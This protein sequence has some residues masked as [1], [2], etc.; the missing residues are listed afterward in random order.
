MKKR[1]IPIIVIVIILALSLAGCGELIAQ[2][3]KAGAEIGE[4]IHDA[5][6]DSKFK[7]QA[8]T[9]TQYDEVDSF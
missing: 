5:V 9:V 7:K 3:I 2:T 8:E 6:E 1:K 4:A